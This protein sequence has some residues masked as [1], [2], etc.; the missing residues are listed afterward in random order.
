MKSRFILH[1]MIISGII[2]LFSCTKDFEEMNKDPDGFTTA[3][4]GSLFNG[5]ISSLR[6]GS[7]EQLYL[8]NEIFYKQTQ[9]AALTKEAWGNYPL[10]TNDMWN[11][12][13]D[14]FAPVRELEERFAEYENSENYSNIVAEVNNMKAMLKVTVAYK[15]FR[16]TDIFGDIPFIDAGYGFQGLEYLYPVYNNQEEIYKYLLDDLKWVDE[17][18][19]DT[20]DMGEPFLTFSNFDNLFFGDLLQWKKFANSL[21]LRYAMRMSEKDLDFAGPIIKEIIEE[22]RPVF[23][24]Y[25][26][27]TSE[28]ESACMIP[29]N[30]GFRKGGTFWAFDQHKNLRMGSKIWQ[31]MS[32]HDS[33]DGSGIFDPR[34][35]IFFEE[36]NNGDW[37]AF[38]QIPE[39]NTPTSGGDPY[40]K[41]RDSETDFFIKGEGC[42][43]SPFNYFLLRDYDFMPIIF[44][45]GAEVHFIKAEAY[46]RGI[47]VPQDG[48]AADIEY[49][50]GIN[51]SIEWWVKTAKTLQLAESG[52]NFGD[53]DTIPQGLGS[54][55]VLT[56]WG[57][58]LATSDEEKLEF[59]YAQRWLDAFR[60]P[61]EAYAL[62]RRT[63]KTPRDGEPIN[64]FR[65][66]YPAS[67]LEFNSVNCSDA[68]GNQGG[69]SPNIKLWWI[70]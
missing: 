41:G 12:Y 21:R 66:P 38:P 18:I 47:G 59:I 10:G 68:I 1:T 27:I 19:N 16:I 26:F 49:M 32:E 61:V 29:I 13:Y 40:V 51:S 64:H 45:T 2:F 31:M 62:A 8:Q 60:Q 23:Y 53:V 57:P 63:G 7:N 50:N 30:T 15:T 52:L 69:D 39:S 54:A 3:S 14:D 9:Q 42:I 48:Q 65:M 35:Y 22:D 36:N 6:P 43:Y 24:G 44:I 20:A 55:S 34:A 37:V 17:N 25:D 5:I 28:L 4:E 11:S 33:T 46:L 70:P 67:E 58:W 56:K